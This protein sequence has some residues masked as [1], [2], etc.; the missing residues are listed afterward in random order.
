[1]SLAQLLVA[2]AAPLARRVFIALGL[3]WVVY[4]GVTTAVDTMLTNAA[5]QMLGLPP[6]VLAL[7]NLAGVFDGFGL[8][9]GAFIARLAMIPL[10]Q[11]IPDQG[12]SS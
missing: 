10:A 5:A 12:V 9:T 6:D 8:L 7:L 11:I 2:L 1:M 3:A 4:E